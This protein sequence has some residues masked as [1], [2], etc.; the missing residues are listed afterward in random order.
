MSL[1]RREG[2]ENF[3]YFLDQKPYRLKNFAQ[4]LAEFNEL[5]TLDHGGLQRINA[6]VHRYGGHLV[7]KDNIASQEAYE[8]FS[9]PWT[10]A[11]LGLNVVWDLA[12]YAG[13][14]V[15]SANPSHKWGL[16]LGDEHRVSRQLAGY[17]RPCVFIAW[18]PVRRFHLFD[19]AFDTARTKREVMT[20]GSFLVGNPNAPP[21]S[22]QRVL[23]FW[24]GRDPQQSQPGR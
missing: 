24:A 8:L 6:W 4:L 14:Y 2:E 15:T 16:D 17:L 3:A 18:R 9:P 21:D 10:D 12:I 23:T 20:I 7:T 19:F 13:E 11:N 5:A 22:L 1:S